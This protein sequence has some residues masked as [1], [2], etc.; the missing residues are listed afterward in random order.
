LICTIKFL[1]FD[2]GV[3]TIDAS[4]SIVQYYSKITPIVNQ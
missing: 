4:K 3:K 2:F 1:M